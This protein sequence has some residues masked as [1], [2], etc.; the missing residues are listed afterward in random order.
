[1]IGR[2]REPSIRRST[3]GLYVYVN[4]TPR[5]NWLGSLAVLTFQPF[6]ENPSELLH[7]IRGG[8]DF[9]PVNTRFVTRWA[10]KGEDK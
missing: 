5:K 7:A 2:N 9:Y 6:P 8:I 3:T 1:M 10:A 4:A